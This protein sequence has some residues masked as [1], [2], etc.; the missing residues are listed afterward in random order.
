MFRAFLEQSIHQN[1]DGIIVGEMHSNNGCI[2]A[3]HDS[4]P[5][6]KKL[7]E[8]KPVAVFCEIPSPRGKDLNEDVESL[9]SWS[10][11]LGECFHFTDD[12][13]SVLQAI[14]CMG[15]QIY[16]FETSHSN[17]FMKVKTIQEISAVLVELGLSMIV[18]QCLEA[19][20]CFEDFLLTAQSAYAKTD[21]RLI[22]T[23][24]EVENLIQK[25]NPGTFTILLVGA[26]HIPYLAKNRKVVE[27]GI[28]ER[29][30]QLGRYAATFATIEQCS[31]PYISL[32]EGDEEYGPIQHVSQVSPRSLS[33][34]SR[35]ASNLSSFWA[36]NPKSLVMG[37]G[38]TAATLCVISSMQ[39]RR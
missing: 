36:I 16:G 26:Q 37:L 14:S 30:N 22:R 31:G 6:L 8:T 20:L 35:V 28:L 23:N 29:L 18:D 33:K 39:K 27:V 38:I 34:P 13:K 7:S 2:L 10:D 15:I 25:L 9:S 19:E 4:L 1:Q 21:A 11:K 12:H 32:G 3:M 5:I 17:P 24:E